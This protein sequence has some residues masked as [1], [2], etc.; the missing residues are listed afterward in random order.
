MSDKQTDTEATSHRVAEARASRAEV[1]AVR[2]ETRAAELS[3]RVEQAEERE[4]TL[5]DQERRTRQRLDAFLSSFPGL[6]WESY[7]DPDPEAGRAMYVGGNVGLLQ[8]Y[9]VE[10]WM[11]PSFWLQIVHPEDG[12]TIKSSMERLMA[13]GHGSIL[14]RWIAKN[15][16]ISWMTAQITVIRDEAGAPIGLRGIALDVTELKQAEAERNEALV[17]ESVLRAQQESLLEL[18]TPLVPIDDDVLAMTL[19][20]G[21]DRA[22]ADRVLTTLLEGVSRAGARVVILDVTGVPT[23][24]TGTADAL[25]RA[26]R[27][28]SLLGAEIVLT[29]IRSEVARTLVGLGVDLESMTTKSTLKA[30]IAHALQRKRAFQAASAD[31][32]ARSGRA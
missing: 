6:L 26:A 7:F 32:R 30:G 10:D 5:H 25:L 11:K 27:A 23:V 1:R 16:D 21:I 31:K 14:Y 22:R 2:A 19:V 28:V 4:R 8:G 13:D 3:V 12:E 20:G 18:S 9:T 29:G 24:D 17:R 15:G